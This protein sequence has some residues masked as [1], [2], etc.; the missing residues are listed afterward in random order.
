LIVAAL[1]S[2]LQPAAANNSGSGREPPGALF[3]SPRQTGRGSGRGVRFPSKFNFAQI[4][5]DKFLFPGV[6]YYPNAAGSPLQRIPDGRKKFKLLP[7]NLLVGRVTPCA[8][9]FGIQANGAHGE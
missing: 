8:P 5:R 1:N 7:M 3:P 4:R 9:G 6:F 2:N